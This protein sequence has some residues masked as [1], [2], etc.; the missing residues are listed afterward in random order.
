MYTY[1][2]DNNASTQFQQQQQPEHMHMHL[3]SNNT[4]I[5]CRFD[6][7]NLDRSGNIT[8]GRSA[9]TKFVDN[10]DWH[11]KS[12]D[13]KWEKFKFQSKLKQ[14]EQ[15]I[16]LQQLQQQLTQLP[17]TIEKT[18]PSSN[19]HTSNPCLN[20]NLSQTGSFDTTMKDISKLNCSQLSN[21]INTNT[22]RS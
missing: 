21:G 10:N 15:L 11:T 18:P 13:S 8:Q 17:Q 6:H 19:S 14:L 22:Q 5:N 9:R 3:P 16:Q 2:I 4:N 7:C 12:N 1:Y 20:H